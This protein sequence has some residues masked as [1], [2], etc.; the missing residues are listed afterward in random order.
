MKQADSHPY[1]LSADL[2]YILEKTYS[3]WEPL[4]N[5]R[6]FITGGTGFFGSW[7]LE[8]F[9]WANKALHLNSKA[10]VLTR[11]PDIFSK[12]CP[13]LYHETCLEFHEGEVSNFIYP[14]GTFSHLI[15][16]ATDV[17]ITPLYDPVVRLNTII[18]GCEHVLEFARASE[19]KN[20]LLVSSGAVYGKQPA[21]HLLLAEDHPS[22][23]DCLD[24]NASY[25]IGKSA[26]EHLA[27]LYAR[28]YNFAVKIARCFSF[29]GPYLPLDSHLAINN[30]IND[31]LNGKPILVKGDGTSL[32]SY[33]YAADL[34]VWLWTILFKGQSLRPYNVGSEEKISMVELAKIIA[35]IF[36]EKPEITVMQSSID[37]KIPERYLPDINRAK[38]ELGLAAE[39]NL[40]QAIQSTCDWFSRIKEN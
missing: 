32:R 11:N 22:Q 35:S 7:L 1:C 30:F 31:G 29:V 16:A 8:S 17:S 25:A 3:L 39:R 15:H 27:A 19:V 37:K 34:T 40:K 6:I 18:K 26:A 28:K 13:H 2:D 9:V 10:V 21:D 14:A 23:I 36:K 24:L 20:F 33:L 5:Q 4:R 12:K 38:T